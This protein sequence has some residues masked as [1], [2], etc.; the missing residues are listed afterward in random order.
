MK[1]AWILYKTKVC[2]YSSIT[3]YNSVTLKCCLNKYFSMNYVFSHVQTKP[4]T[5]FYQCECFSLFWNTWTKLQMWQWAQISWCPW[6]SCIPLHT[7]IHLNALSSAEIFLKGSSSVKQ[8]SQWACWAAASFSYRWPMCS[9][10][11]P[12]ATPQARDHISTGALRSH[13]LCSLNTFSRGFAV[14]LMDNHFQNL[15]GKQK[16]TSN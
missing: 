1:I 10:M 7:G 2:D 3:K 14:V 5:M 9:S 11:F 13:C 8:L 16:N 15:V 4:T 6:M 12:E